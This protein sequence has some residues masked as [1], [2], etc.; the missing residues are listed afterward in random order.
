MN[1]KDNLEKTVIDELRL[2]YKADSC[3]LEDL[4]NIEIGEKLNS[5]HSTYT[6]LIVATSK[7]DSIYI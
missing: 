6:E 3:L 5:R 7:L 1:S 2:C 4:R